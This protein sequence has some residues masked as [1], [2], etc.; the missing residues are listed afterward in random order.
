M[1]IIREFETQNF[2]VIVEALEDNDVDLSFDETG[3]VLR[4]LQDGTL[5]RV[6]TIKPIQIKNNGT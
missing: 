1:N 6:F 4:D 5:D 3:E 2:R